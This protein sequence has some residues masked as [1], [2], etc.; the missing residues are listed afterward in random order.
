MRQTY[1]VELLT[2]FFCAGAD[3]AKPEIRVPSIRGHLR[4]W[5]E[6]MRLG[7]VADTWGGVHGTPKASKVA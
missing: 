6:W 7:P 4:D 5:H 1:D 3:P 2:P